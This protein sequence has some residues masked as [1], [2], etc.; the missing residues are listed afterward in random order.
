LRYVLSATREPSSLAVGVGIERIIL[1]TAG[2]HCVLDRAGA[3]YRDE[4]ERITLPLAGVRCAGVY[5]DRVGE[6]GSER[7][8][9]ADAA[10]AKLA[11]AQEETEDERGESGSERGR[12]RSRDLRLAARHS[13]RSCG[14]GV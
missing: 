14:R 4:I 8:S 6:R 13:A 1:S 12:A 5:R 11:I 10:D 2:V 9:D 7:D 3:L